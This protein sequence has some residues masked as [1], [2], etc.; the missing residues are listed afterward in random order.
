MMQKIF[1]N[2]QTNQKKYWIGEPFWGKGIIT[3]ALKLIIDKAFKIFPVARLYCR[4]FGNNPRSMKVLNKVSFIL[5]GKYEL[6]LKKNGEILDEYIYAKRSNI[7]S[8]RE[9]EDRLTSLSSLF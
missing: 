4:V 8:Y 3:E 1:V 2:L 9:F 5:V 7:N 6:T